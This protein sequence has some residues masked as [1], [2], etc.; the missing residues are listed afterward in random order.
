MIETSS[1]IVFM[2][3]AFVL[4]ITPGPAVL[5]IVARSLEQGRG[6]GIVYALAAGAAR[7]FLEGNERWANFQNKFAGTVYIGLGVA[8]ALSGGNSK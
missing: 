6:A 4:L 5:F 7:S 1:L 3:A 8:T 2:T